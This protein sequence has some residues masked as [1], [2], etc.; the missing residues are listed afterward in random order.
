MGHL[1]TSASA[2][3]LGTCDTLLVV[4]SNDPWT[5]FYPRPGQARAVQV[6]LDGRHLGNRYPVD[7]GL[8]G[9][10]TETLER[11]L[12]LL[13]ERED[14]SFRQE[15]EDQVRRWH[16]LAERRAQLPARPLNPEL[17]VRELSS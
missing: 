6:D 5:E 10:A 9:D 2:W 8:T 13:R 3:L 1:G 17:V 15:T 14:A 12:P 16:D 4:G 7:V 11:L